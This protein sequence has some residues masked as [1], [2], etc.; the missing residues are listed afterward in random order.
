MARASFSCTSLRVLPYTYF[1]RRTPFSARKLPCQRPSLRWVI[2]PSPEPRR[3]PLMAASLLLFA[4]LREFSRIETESIAI[5]SN[6]HVGQGMYWPMHV[7]TNGFPAQVQHVLHLRHLE[8]LKPRWNDTILLHRHS[9][10]YGCYA[11]HLYT[12]LAHRL[13]RLR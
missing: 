11:G 13:P 1:L 5:L 10:L 7:C 8:Q 2:P 3:L 12:W 4:P 9:S 6:T